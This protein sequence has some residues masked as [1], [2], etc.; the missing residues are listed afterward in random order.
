MNAKQYDLDVDA[1]EDVCKVLRHAADKYYEAQVELEGAWGEVGVGN[2]WTRLARKL[3]RA[4]A[5][6]EKTITQWEKQGYR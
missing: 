3:D 4:A 2:I 6:C 5:D 1:P